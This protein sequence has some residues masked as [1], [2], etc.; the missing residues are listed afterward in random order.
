MASILCKYTR[1]K[2]KDLKH[3]ACLAYL[4]ILLLLAV[5]VDMEINE[6][7]RIEATMYKNTKVAKV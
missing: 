3:R 7:W 6:T 4:Q 5:R 1:T 2:L